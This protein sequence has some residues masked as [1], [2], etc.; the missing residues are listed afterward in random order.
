[1]ND[2]PI[3]GKTVRW[4]Y[5]DEPTAGTHFEH[6]FEKDGTVRYR[7]LDGEGQGG[8]NGKDA[9]TEQPGYET[10]KVGEDVYAVSYLA[11]S[12]WTLTTLID[13]KTNRIVSF[14]SNEKQLLVQHGTMEAS[15]AAS[16]R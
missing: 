7:M 14:A 9:A 11:P 4:S 6:T 16:A 13:T 3:R 5:S 2:D 8:S 10:A 1:M 15:P 12:G